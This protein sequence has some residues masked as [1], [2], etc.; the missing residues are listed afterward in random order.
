MAGVVVVV[1]DAVD[2]LDSTTSCSIG[3]GFAFVFLLST[4]SVA[5]SPFK[6]T[7]LL[8]LPMVKELNVASK[9]VKVGLPNSPRKLQPKN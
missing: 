7:F 4:A 5:P 3:S 1:A 8:R 9:I 2:T 6:A